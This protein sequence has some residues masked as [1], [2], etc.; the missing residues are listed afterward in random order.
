[1]AHSTNL[2]GT[3]ALGT[4]GRRRSCV[5]SGTVAIVASNSC[6]NRNGRFGAEYGLIEFK[7]KNYFEIGAARRARRTL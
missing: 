4:G 1:L 2:T 3:V 6:A 7:F 5:G